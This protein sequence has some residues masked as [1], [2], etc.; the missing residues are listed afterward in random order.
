MQAEFV[1]DLC[2]RAV[3][4][5]S[6]TKLGS[7]KDISIDVDSGRVVQ[8]AVKHGLLGGAELL[9]APEEVIEI[10]FDAIIVKDTLVRAG[11]VVVA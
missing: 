6:G 7:L 8:Y 4:T 9:V 5:Q 1:H 11:N 2:G 10:R 3:I